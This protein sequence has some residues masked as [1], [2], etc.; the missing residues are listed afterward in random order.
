MR[1]QDWLVSI[2]AGILLGVVATVL[3]LP[4]KLAI[5]PGRAAGSIDNVLTLILNSHTHWSTIKGEAEVTWYG[6]N[7]GTQTYINQFQISQPYSAYINIINKDQPGFNEGLWISDGQ[8]IY[9]L[10]KTKKSYTE[11]NIPD[12]AKK[13]VLMPK[14]LSEVSTDVVYN[15][16]FSLLIPAPVKEYIYP[17]WFV[18]GNSTL[19]YQVTGQEQVL[20]RDTWVVLLK[21]KTGETTA[22]IDQ[23]TGMIL[24]Y[25]QK[26]NG[27]L[28]EKMAFTSLEVDSSINANTFMVPAGYTLTK[29]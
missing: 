19:S 20:G 25:E 22:W 11:N 1:K 26:E 8:K 27:Q 9:E 28:S 4:G 7:G 10:D 3:G 15:H 17:E 13:F 12:F 6:P 2:I 14:N 23:A 29:P 24:R 5:Q 18:Q 21:T 16:P